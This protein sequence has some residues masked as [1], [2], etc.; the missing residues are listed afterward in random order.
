E[1]GRFSVGCG[2]VDGPPVSRA[3][4]NVC[5]R[6]DE[7]RVPLDLVEQRVRETMYEHAASKTGVQVANTSSTLEALAGPL[8]RTRLPDRPCATRRTVPLRRTPPLPLD[9][10]RPASPKRCARPAKY[11]GR[12]SGL[13]LPQAKLLQATLSFAHPRLLGV[14]IALVVEA[15]DE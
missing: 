15:C 11:A 10:I 5:G 1:A 12:G 9:G 7:N 3:A 8:G 13:H 14:M 4:A 2:G 6:K